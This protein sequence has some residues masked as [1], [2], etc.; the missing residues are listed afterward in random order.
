METP[1][2]PA[3]LLAWD[4]ELNDM[5]CIV[6]AETAAKARWTAVRAYWE[7]YE[8]RGWPSV[9]AVRRPF[10]DTFP[11]KQPRKAYCPEYVHA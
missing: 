5:H 3:P 9:H 1:T 7:A 11:N 2:A 4:V 6:F 10:L 8:K